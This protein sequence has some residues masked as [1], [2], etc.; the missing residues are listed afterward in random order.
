LRAWWRRVRCF[1]SA[2]PRTAA[3]R[4]APTASSRWE[5]SAAQATRAR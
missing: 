1:A 2:A 4:P 3:A 5:G